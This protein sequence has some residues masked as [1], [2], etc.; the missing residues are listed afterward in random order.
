MARKRQ[1]GEGSW[2]KKNIKGVIYDYF[3]DAQG[4]YTY[5][6]SQKEVK[7]KLEEKKEQKEKVEHVVKADNKLTVGEYMNA[8]LYQKKYK[9]VGIS[10]DVSTFDCYENALTKRFYTYPIAAIQLSALTKQ[11]LQDYLK[12][13]SD[14][15]ARGSI[16]KTWQVLKLGLMDDDFELFEHVPAIDFKR[17]KVPD[18][19]HCAVKA[20]VIKFTSNEDMETL[21]GEALRKTRTGAYYYGNAA[22]LLAFIMYSGLRE[23]EACGL[24]W[25]DVDIDNSLITINQTYNQVSQRDEHGNKIGTTYVLKDPKTDNS[26]ATIPVRQKGV[27]ILEIMESMYPLHKPDDFVFITDTNTPFQKRHVLHT[28]TRILKNCG[29]QDK[30]YTVHE[31]RHGYGSILYQEGVDIYTISKLLRHADIQTTANIYVDTTPETLKNVL[32]GIDVKKKT[33]AV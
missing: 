2:G 28:L 30:K 14:T 21:Y 24:Q 31:L 18:E 16:K 4:H 7:K 33:P 9:E 32:S 12:E 27:E 17:I 26:A 22:K 5:G 8:W 11:A 19:R 23:A 29:L 10:L 20:K 6:R 13:L 1:N 3:R 25:K 15:Y